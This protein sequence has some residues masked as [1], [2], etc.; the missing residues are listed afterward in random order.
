MGS[1]KPTFSKKKDYFFLKKDLNENKK[2]IQSVLGYC[3]Y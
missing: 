3:Q 1:V 2:R